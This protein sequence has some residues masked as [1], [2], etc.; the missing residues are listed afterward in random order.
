[1]AGKSWPATA[2]AAEGAG[3]GRDGG[4]VAAYGG[5]DGEAVVGQLADQLV[6]VLRGGDETKGAGMTELEDLEGRGPSQA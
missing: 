6:E 3:E 1:M 2:S 5:E 4:D